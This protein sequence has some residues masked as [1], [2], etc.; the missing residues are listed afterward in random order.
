MNNIPFNKPFYAGG[1]AAL[2]TEALSGE[3][4]SEGAGIRKACED[5]FCNRYGF[6]FARLTNSCSM[7]LEIAAMLSGC[8]T[9]DEIIM[10]SY[11]FVSTANAFA[12]RGARIIFADS[13]PQNPN[14]SLESVRSLITKKTRAIVVVHYAGIACQME[15]FRSLA[16]EHSILLIEDAAQCIE[17][18]YKGKPLGTIGD[19]SCF[20]FHETKNIHCG[21][22][23]LLVVN[24]KALR[25]QA[26]VLLF[27]GTNRSA[28]S[29]GL[30]RRYEWVAPGHSALP[31][32]VSAL[33][34]YSQLNAVAKVKARRRRIW[35]LYNSALKQLAGQRVQ[36]PVV[37]EGCEHN[38]HTFFLVVESLGERDA[39]IR[40][41]GLQG[42]LAVF[43]YQALHASPY[44]RAIDSTVELPQ[45]ERYTDCLIRLPLY[46]ELSDEQVLFIADRVLEYFNMKGRS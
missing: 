44:Y 33:L 42:I 31:S 8:T 30:V 22:G 4:L 27:K 11:T 18:Y 43:H 40:H 19:I 34:L 28:F 2:L 1:E 39:L 5:F 12:L 45:S 38:A 26:E 16:D 36:L 37:P 14:V 23:G 3:L 6:D 29:R 46:Y 10:P 15:E 32:P 13:E 9:D 35:E 21:E 17:S 25:E 7:A 20:S 24:N 41:L